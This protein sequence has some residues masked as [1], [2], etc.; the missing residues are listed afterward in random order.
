MG[1]D[2]EADSADYLLVLR[3]SINFTFITRVL[4]RFLSYYSYTNLAVFM[5]TTDPFYGPMGTILE[6]T[7][8]KEARSLLYTTKF[9]EF[10]GNTVPEDRYRDMLTT[11]HLTSRGMTDDK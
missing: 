7:M 4:L 6:N 10:D 2:T 5:D 1:A 11:A 9:L 3:I 8:K